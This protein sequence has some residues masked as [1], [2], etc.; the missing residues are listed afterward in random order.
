MRGPPSFAGKGPAPARTATEGAAG[1]GCNGRELAFTHAGDRVVS[2]GYD[3]VLR[4]WDAATG[5][6]LLSRPGWFGV[7]VASD[8]QS[9]G[10]HR[11]GDNY[12]T[13][14]LAGGQELRTL[15]HP[16][17]SGVQRLGG[18][19]LHPNGRLLAATTGGG[20]GFFD[21]PS[22]E[23][24]AFLAMDGGGV[25][26]FDETGALWTSSGAG[27]LR[28]PVQPSAG[29]RRK[30]RIGPP[31][32]VANP[33]AGVSSNSFSADGR[34]AVLPLGSD[35]ALVVHRGPP[36]RSLRL[37]P[38]YDVRDAFVS[39]DGRWIATQSWWVDGSGVKVKIWEADTGKLVANFPY[40]DVNVFSGFLP[41]SIQSPVEDRLVGTTSGTG[42]CVSHYTNAG[43]V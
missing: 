17:A 38:Q 18:L 32:W 40:P 20:N 31:E 25:E 6:L 28:W 26:G 11:E 12:R 2:D 22:C 43:I 33:P 9:V 21:L 35:G 36:R 4:L 42:D 1:S 8:D 27:L 34:V 39:P 37:G 14:R 19:T 23:E 41:D 16:Q 15:H 7:G 13:L 29:S 10:H 5:Q 3:A 24:V 30:L